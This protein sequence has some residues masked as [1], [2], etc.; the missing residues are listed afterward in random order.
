MQALEVELQMLLTPCLINNSRLINLKLP[1]DGQPQEHLQTMRADLLEK[2]LQAITR[3]QGQ[4]CLR[5]R[6]TLQVL[7]PSSQLTNK[8]ADRLATPVKLVLLGQER[9]PQ[10][11]QS[12]FPMPDSK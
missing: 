4:D 6:A 12:S 5:L 7:S 10:V 2:C 9:I 3:T 11:F 8:C 1:R